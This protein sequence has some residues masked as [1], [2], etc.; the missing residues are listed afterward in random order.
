MKARTDVIAML[1]EGHS[2]ASIVRALH[3]DYKTVAATRRTLHI[4]QHKPGKPPAANPQV[5]FDQRVRPVGGG[6]LDWT[7]YRNAAGLAAFRW[8]GRTYTASRFAFE[9]H[10]GRPP[11]GKVIPG[12]DQDGCVQGSHLED[13]PMRQKLRT[14]LASIFGGTS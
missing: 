11:V 8:A 13:Q 1:R 6:H 7:G 5:L 2:D 3:V 14:Q 12:C 4:P 9:T 10:Y